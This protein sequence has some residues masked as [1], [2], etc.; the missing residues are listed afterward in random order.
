MKKTIIFI[1]LCVLFQYT[2][3]YA[4]ETVSIEPDTQFISLGK[5]SVHLLT[6]EDISFAQIRSS[7]YKKK[8]IP[9]SEDVLNLGFNSNAC[10]IHFVI[11]NKNEGTEDYILEVKYG[12]LDYIDIYYFETN[13]PEKITTIKT[14]DRLPLSTRPISH[15]KFIFPLKIN[16]EIQVYVKVK[17]T[18]VLTVPL[19]LWAPHSFFENDRKSNTL[20]ALYYGMISV[21]IFYNLFIYFTIRD[22]S[23]IIYVFHIVAIMFTQLGLNGFLSEIWPNSPNWNNISLS[24]FI[25]CYFLTLIVFTKNFL[26][27]KD[28]LPRLNKFFNILS[29]LLAGLTIISIFMPYVKV[30]R[31]YGLIGLF[32]PIMIFITPLLI[33][34]KFKPARY[35]TVAIFILLLGTLT[36]ALMNFGL[37]PNNVIVNNAPQAGFALEIIILSLGLASKINLLKEEIETQNIELSKLSKLPKSTA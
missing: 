1:V 10:W 34:S 19:T 14:G 22:Q 32:L 24:F 9:V 30:I 29:I 31:I 11:N 17:T 7:Q 35:F 18:G 20:Y 12:L 26:N 27:L 16:K 5:Q 21:M 15:R 2:S 4:I 3:C 37:L 28:Y 25:G 36:V 8:L 33:V 23:Y 13:T 6:A